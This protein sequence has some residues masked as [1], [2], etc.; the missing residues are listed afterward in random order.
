LMDWMPVGNKLIAVAS[1]R[2]Q[3]IT[4]WHNA[5]RILMLALVV[6]AEVVVLVVLVVVV[7]EATV[8][9]TNAHLYTPQTR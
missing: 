6:A 4:V 3:P 8:K 7:A 5:Q 9:H 2:L 1:V